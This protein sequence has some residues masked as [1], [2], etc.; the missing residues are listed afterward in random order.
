MGHRLV[1]RGSQNHE[2]SLSRKVHFGFRNSD[3]RCEAP[4][5]EEQSILFDGF[6]DNREALRPLV[7][8]GP[9]GNEARDDPRVALEVYRAL[10]LSGFSHLSGHFALVLWDA[11][12]RRLVL[13]RD[14]YGARPLYFARQ[15]D[16]FLFASEYK[17]L[18]AIPEVPA[19]PNLD[20]IQYLLRTRFTK[21]DESFLTGIDPVPPGYW[22]SVDNGALEAQRYWS[23]TIDVVARTPGEHSAYLR[24]AILD[25]TKRQTE[26][27]DPIG[28]SLS[29]GVDS[30]LTVAAIDRVWPEKKI[31]TFTGGFGPEDSELKQAAEV[32]EY[33]GTEHHEIVLEPT[34]LPEILESVVWFL[35]DPAGREETAFFYVTSRKASKY[36]SMLMAG[37]GIDLLFGGM[38]RH[39]L[40]NLAFKLPLGQRSLSEFL[41]YTQSGQ[42]PETLGGRLLTSMYY[43]GKQYPV[44]RVMGAQLAPHLPLV[45]PEGEQPLTQYLL[46]CLSNESV[47]SKTERL[48]SCFGLS[49]NS[50]CMDPEIITCAAQIP[51]SLKIKGRTQKYILRRACEGLLPGS[52]LMRKKTLQKLEHGLEF[53]RV[54]DQLAERYLASSAVSS[55]GLFEPNYVDRLLRRSATEAY[56]TE[57]AYRLWSLILTEVWCR[58]YLDQRGRPLPQEPSLTEN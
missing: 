31:H 37:Y 25:A 3:V 46:Q 43:R 40:A 17:A 7:G 14:R 11:P 2:W 50:P 38:P 55:R 22:L 28:V 6:L 51:D 48:H 29:G 44:P 58:Q 9:P 5:F 12:N 4:E 49:F 18:L 39:F 26:R 10:G 20:A 16:R 47:E 45:R 53:S 35:E 32:A 52:V 30:A 21:T 24:S 1:H 57:R 42:I 33:F 36:V 19:A 27:Y 56:S 8:N 34:E 23:V 15:G 54:L 13:A 41:T